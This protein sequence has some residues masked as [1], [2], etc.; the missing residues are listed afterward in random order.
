MTAVLFLATALLWGG[1]ALA[2]ALQAGPVA[3]TF[4]RLPHGAA[5]C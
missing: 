5:A 2:T 1:G 3:A 4:G